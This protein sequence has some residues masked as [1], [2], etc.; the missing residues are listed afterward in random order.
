MSARRNGSIPLYRQLVTTLRY[1]IASGALRPGD[2]LP[3]LREG[4]R[5]W[6]V[7]LH[8]VRRAYQALAD[9]GLVDLAPGRAARVTRSATTLDQP[10]PAEATIEDFAGWVRLEARR[11]F[12]SEALRLAELLGTIGPPVSSPHMVVVECTE[13]MARRLADQLEEATGLPVASCILT[14]LPARQESVAVATYHHHREVR[15][16]ARQCG[17]AVRFLPVA[18]APECLARISVA[19]PA[20]RL[21]LTGPEVA[22]LAAMA[23]ELR[24]ALGSGYQVSVVRS[25]TPDQVVSRHVPDRLV[26]CT[27]EAWQRLD[28]RWR[29]NPRVIPHESSWMPDALDE[30]S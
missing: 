15:D 25:D 24:R 4:E 21:V 16:I 30:L 22:S 26:V 19:S 5:R 3:A 18:V 8:T 20:R 6:R 11:R 1:R 13:A 28:A 17:M 29:S 9:E 7:S 2:R 23:G 12:G 27:P 14:E 10:L